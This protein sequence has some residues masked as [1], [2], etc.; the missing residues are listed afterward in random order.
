MLDIVLINIDYNIGVF[1]KIN[2]KSCKPILKLKIKS[3]SK[4]EGFSIENN[5]SIP[6]PTKYMIEP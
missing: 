4:Q 2:V 5:I 6:F 1:I 3:N